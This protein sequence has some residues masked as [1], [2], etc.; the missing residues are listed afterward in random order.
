VP[1]RAQEQVIFASWVYTLVDAIGPLLLALA[2]GMIVTTLLFAYHLSHKH[3]IGYYW[4]SLRRSWTIM[5]SRL[6]LE[7]VVLAALFGTVRMEV[8]LTAPY[9]V[10][11][12]LIVGLLWPIVPGLVMQHL[13][14]TMSEEKLKGWLAPLRK[15]ARSKFV[16]MQMS[17]Q[18]LMQQDNI[19]CQAG[20]NDWRIE[21]VSG[22]RMRRRIRWVYEDYREPIAREKKD[23]RFLEHTYASHPGRKFQLL[24][25]HL[26]RQHLRKA[27][28]EK[29][30]HPTWDGKQERRESCEP[31]ANGGRR[32]DD[33]GLLAEI[34]QGESEI[35]FD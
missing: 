16:D 6:A 35:E 19:D 22:E 33:P 8:P 1:A 32:Y 27:L 7:F 34:G 31:R 5:A 15:I 26:G 23:A 29:D 18:R 13:A 20:V 11:A 30:G 2:A 25:R 3:C 21:G 28:S 24:V 12:A 17:T 4:R 14:K 9:T 10:P